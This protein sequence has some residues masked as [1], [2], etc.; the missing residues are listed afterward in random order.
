M[1][2]I[3]DEAQELEA[4]HLASSLA[5]HAAR[6]KHTARIAPSGM[7]HNPECVEDFGDNTARLFCGPACAERFEAIN[8]HRNS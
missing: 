7:C 5:A 6:A 4:R 3:I 8:Q 1:T 2:D